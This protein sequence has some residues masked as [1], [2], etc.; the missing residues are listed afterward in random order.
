M[1][2]VLN[3]EISR[4]HELMNLHEGQYNNF[5]FLK[6]RV[7][8]GVESELF[9]D[10]ISKASDMLNKKKD[11]IGGV[12]DLK[13]FTNT[14]VGIMFDSFFDGFVRRGEEFPPELESGE[15][16]D[17]LLQVFRDDIEDRYYEITN[18][19]QN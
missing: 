5:L 2:K 18:E 1:R 13:K 4:I 8:L 3:E 7:P 17:F 15:I 10:A 12:Y 11:K 14:V 6:R 19:L 16:W 9:S